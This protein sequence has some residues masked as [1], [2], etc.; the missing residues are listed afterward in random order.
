MP[1][2]PEEFV[3]IPVGL[4]VVL[5]AELIIFTPFTLKHYFGGFE[6]KWARMS[7]TKLGQM[8][9]WAGEMQ[10]GVGALALMYMIFDALCVNQISRIEVEILFL[11]HALWIGCCTAFCPP[12]PAFLLLFGMNPHFYLTVGVWCT[13]TKMARPVCLIVSGAIMLFGIYRQYFQFRSTIFPNEPFD[14]DT[15]GRAQTE[16][17]MNTMEEVNAALR[18]ASPVDHLMKPPPKAAKEEA[19]QPAKAVSTETTPLLGS[20]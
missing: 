16:L 9:L 18:K 7:N 1:I 14:L 10:N 3:G 12:P 20:K 11:S 6:P 17:N 2:G 15:F 13:A 5:W 4:K 8:A 19:S